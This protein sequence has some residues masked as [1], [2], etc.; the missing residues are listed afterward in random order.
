MATAP[1]ILLV[2]D[3]PQNLYL[4][5]ELLDLEGYHTRSAASGAEALAIA[6]QDPPQLLLLDVMM[7]DMN[8]F[9]VC[10][11]LRSHSSLQT[12]PVIFLTALGD[13]DSRLKGLDVMGDD[14]LTKPIN[15]DLVVKKIE[16]LLRLRQLR[17]DS[18]QKALADQMQV[19]RQSQ[20]QVKR[21]MM[22]AWKINEALSEKFRLF[23]PDQMLHRIAPKGL[24][25]IQL[26][27]AFESDLTI[28]FCDIRDFTTIVES[29]EALQTFNWLNA[30][31]TALNQAIS[32]HNGF[33]DKYLGD[34]VMAVFD[35]DQTHVVDG[36]NAAIAISQAI[37]EFNQQYA[38]FNLDQPIRIGIG[39]HSGRGVIGTVGA[40]QRMDPT[41]IGDVVNTAARLEELTKVYNCEIISSEAVVDQLPSGHPFTI[42]WLEQMAPRGKKK[43]LNLYEVQ[44]PAM[45]P[46]PPL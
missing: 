8:G 41:V 35:H 6:E 31:F 46:Q 18:Y 23:V 17:D 37:Q 25:S 45:I 24:E 12:I 27:N 34:A 19:L 22:A 28:L 15:A 20:E 43:A 7:P 16:S 44:S 33:I 42:R 13:D 21:Q 4:L 10:Q 36:L 14:Y 26:G 2:D 39:L 3:E 29:Q 1:Y 9:E 40:N 11:Q 38:Q 30:F 5:E 32:I